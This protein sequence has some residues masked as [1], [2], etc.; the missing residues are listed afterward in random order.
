MLKIRT[1]RRK[2]LSE[3]VVDE[4]ER[5]IAEEYPAP[6]AKLPTEAE[7]AERYHVSR[8][9]IREAMKVLEDRGAVEVRAG[10]GTLTVAP[11]SDCVKKV[12][13]RLYRN[14][15]VPTAEEM[16][17]LLEVRQV[18][19]ETVASLAA[20]RA[21]E[22]DLAEIEA[23]LGEMNEGRLGPDLM[24][25]SDLRFH[26]GLARAVHNRYF[27]MLLDPLMEVLSQQI[28]LTNAFNLGLESHRAVLKQVRARNPVGARQAMRRLIKQTLADCRKALK[29]YTPS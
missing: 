14:Q 3:W 9:V 8:I 23:A 17:R 25:A 22:E 1:F 10:R 24:I 6:D 13:L 20:V 21:S 29:L 19:E 4:I 2:R 28:K 11:N 27:E 5:M 12:L 18:L 16:E 26:R 7:L 15:P